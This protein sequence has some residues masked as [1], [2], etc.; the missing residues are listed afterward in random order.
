MRRVLGVLVGVLGLSVV[1]ASPALADGI[2]ISPQTSGG[3]FDYGTVEIGNSPGTTFHFTNLLKSKT[4]PLR[5]SLSGSTAFTKS[6]D[7][8]KGTRLA[9]GKSCLV[10]ITY[11]P[12]TDGQTDTASLTANNQARTLEYGN[13]NLS[14]TGHGTA[15]LVWTPSST[16]DF[17]STGG[18][19]GFT[20]TNVGTAPAS[21]YT[22]SILAYVTGV[23]TPTPFTC[24]LAIVGP[25]PVGASCT[26]P[27][28]FDPTQCSQVPGGG[29]LHGQEVFDYYTDSTKTTQASAV[30]DL[31]A[32]CPTN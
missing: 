32:T 21:I 29:Q 7:T 6:R 30:L 9:P 15:D 4:A 1:V 28:V 13:L 22:G 23:F 27:W 10:R 16:Y 19:K 3:A 25:F 24:Y 8:C 18:S 26:E 17:G 20:I 5:I 12:T 2:A 14:G 31:Y 11:T